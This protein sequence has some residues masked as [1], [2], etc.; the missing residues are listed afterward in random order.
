MAVFSTRFPLLS[1]VLPAA[2][3]LLALAAAPT[4]ARASFRLVPIEMEMEPSGRGATQIFRVENDGQDPVAIEISTMARG[5]D[6]Q[7]QDVLSDAEDSF[8]VFP[9]QIIL[10]PGENQSVRVQ[11]IGDAHPARELPF[12]LIAQQ[13][14]INLN[15]GPTEG[16]QVRL[17]VKYVA[18]VYVVPTGAAAKLSVA[19]TAAAT[20]KTDQGQTIPALEIVV[21]ND[22]G[23]HKVMRDLEVKLSSGGKEITL[24][25]EQLKGMIGENVLPGVSRHF[26]IPW[27]ADLPNGPVSASLIL[28]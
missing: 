17:L 21:R 3:L 18:S 16:G 12:R 23:A 1:L 22:G 28:P 11:W 8:S 4:P 25:K 20:L 26:L 5:M 6:D 2:A 19:S 24:G 10:Q 14:D 9:E 15:K 7:G 27:P 13:L